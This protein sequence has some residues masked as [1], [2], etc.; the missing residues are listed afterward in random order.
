[1]YTHIRYLW[2]CQLG[3]VLALASVASTA[4]AE[5]PWC[6]WK[7][8]PEACP[9]DPASEAQQQVERFREKAERKSERTASR[10][11]P[12]LPKLTSPLTWL[13]ERSKTIETRRD[14]SQEERAYLEE[15]RRQER[16]GVRYEAQK[17]LERDSGPT[18]MSADVRLRYREQMDTDTPEIDLEKTAELEKRRKELQDAIKKERAQRRLEDAIERYLRRNPDATPERSSLALRA[19]G[20]DVTPEKMR[21]EMRQKLRQRAECGGCQAPQQCGPPREPL[22]DAP[23]VVVYKMPIQRET[24]FVRSDFRQAEIFQLPP[25]REPVRLPPCDPDCTD[26]P[27]GL[28]AVPPEGCASGQCPVAGQSGKQPPLVPQG[29]AAD[30]KPNV[31][32]QP[33]RSDKLENQNNPAPVP[34]QDIRHDAPPVQPKDRLTQHDQ[35]VAPP[36]FQPTWLQ[37]SDGMRFNIPAGYEPVVRFAE[38]R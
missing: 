21:E 6:P 2:A 9:N 36:D 17:A 10:A 26:R 1:M 16:D 35:Y 37:R 38:E 14:I 23:S 15:R 5:F 20:H 19:E 31:P 4:H 24:R 7:S 28:P 11:I 13:N 30:P 27:P 8:K 33:G 3:M 29:P 22:E 18:I 32:P 12:Y 34:K 25:E